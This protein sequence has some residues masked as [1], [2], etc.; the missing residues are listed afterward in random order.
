VV[1]QEEVTTPPPSPD[2]QDD[3]LFNAF[4][5]FSVK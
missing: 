3:I 2:R 4:N 5:L 1:T